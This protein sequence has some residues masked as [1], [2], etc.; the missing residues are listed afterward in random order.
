MMKSEASSAAR[1][2]FREAGAAPVHRP[3][4]TVS[5]NAVAVEERQRQRGGRG[6]P[7]DPGPFV[8]TR[9]DPS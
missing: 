5:L 9:D 1:R 8:E 3:G 6:S 4:V 2:S 7:G